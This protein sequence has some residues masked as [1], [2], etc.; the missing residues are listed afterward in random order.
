MLL[1]GPAIEMQKTLIL[2]KKIIFSEEARFDLRID[3]HRRHNKGFWRDMTCIHVIIY[4]LPN[5]GV[6]ASVPR[7]GLVKFGCHKFW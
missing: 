1:S 4:I 6:K 5:N 3:V 7:E 2:T